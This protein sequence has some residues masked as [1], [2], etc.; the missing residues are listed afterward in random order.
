MAI[1]LLEY[2]CIRT[3][4]YYDRNVRLFHIRFHLK[5]DLQNVPE[6]GFWLLFFRAPNIQT[7]IAGR[8]LQGCFAATGAVMVSGTIADIWS[9]AEYVHHLVF[10][11]YDNDTRR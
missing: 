6:P 11:I 9:V 3:Y 7:V 4:V 2:H 5:C 1:V 8:F 10:L